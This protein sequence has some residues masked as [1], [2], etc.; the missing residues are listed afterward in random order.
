VPIGGGRTLHMLCEGRGSPTIIL[1]SGV[2]DGMTVW[3]KVQPALAQ[4]HRACAYDRAGLGLSPAGPRPR[5]L[6]AV[7]DDLEMLV[8][9]A[10][11]RPPY[12]LVGH[13]FG[14]LTMRLYARRHLRQVAGL[15]LVDPPKEREVDRAEKIA[16]GMKR[17]LELE[18]ERSRQCASAKDLTGDCEPG[19]PDDAPPKIAAALESVARLHFLTQSLEMAGFLGED[20]AEIEK[21]G[22]NLGSIPLIVLTSEQFKNN[23]EMPPATRAAVE[24]LWMTMHDEIA[25]QST[26]GTNRIVL[27]TGHYIQLERPDAVISAVEEAASAAR[28][29]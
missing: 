10:H 20:D 16:P 11:L 12:L 17:S 9:R 24:Q 27:R 6:N 4:H 26:R 8:T 5:D 29:R 2:G 14:T 7:V 25:A 15:A 13:S 1:E 22:T 21:E 28:H 18:V 23:H 3:R 19:L